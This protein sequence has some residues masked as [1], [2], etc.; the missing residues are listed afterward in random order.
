MYIYICTW[1]Y[2]LFFRFLGS[3]E[4]EGLDANLFAPLL[5]EFRVV[6]AVVAMGSWGSCDFSSKNC[7]KIWEKWGKM[8][9]DRRIY[10][11][12]TSFDDF[13]HVCSMRSFYVTFYIFELLNP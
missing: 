4:V 3:T 5:R 6:P 7:M 13:S 9:K 12:S 2:I 1:I 10:I 8:G 11:Q